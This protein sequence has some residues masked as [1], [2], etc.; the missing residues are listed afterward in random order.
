VR[1]VQYK[2]S[3][4]LNTLIQYGLPAKRPT[5]LG[6][7]FESKG[8]D[9]LLKSRKERLAQEEAG[10]KE[11]VA[12]AAE[13]DDPGDQGSEGEPEDDGTGEAVIENPSQASTPA[14]IQAATKIQK[15]YRKY[16]Q[17]QP[18]REKG[19]QLAKEDTLF[20][21]CLHTFGYRQELPD[22]YRR[23]CLWRL[24]ALLALVDALD[25]VL[26]NLKAHW[27]KQWHQADNIDAADKNLK[28]IGCVT[29]PPA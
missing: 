8:I 1:I 4:D 24:P 12:A 28:K 13:D 17:A 11:T 22:N 18:E 10:K 6:S 16:I 9:D 29:T 7:V 26:K 19:R 15:E 25:P 3:N 21:R 20:R 14:E 27:K 2:D 23:V 5:F